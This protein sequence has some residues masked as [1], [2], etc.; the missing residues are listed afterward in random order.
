MVAQKHNKTAAFLLSFILSFYST[1][2]HTAGVGSFYS[3][4]APTVSKQKFE[5]NEVQCIHDL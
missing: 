3:T 4:D 5:S 1:A 2:E